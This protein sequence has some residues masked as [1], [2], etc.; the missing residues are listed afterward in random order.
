[1]KEIIIPVW[2]RYALTVNEA[3]EYYHIGESK[4]RRIAE[5]NPYAD[6]I[7]MNGNRVLFKRKRFEDFLDKATAV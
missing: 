2:E 1:M 5:E 3:A 7:I 4:L 6:F